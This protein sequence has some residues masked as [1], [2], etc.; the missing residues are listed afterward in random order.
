M[1]ASHAFW[2]HRAKVRQLILM[3][4]LPYIRDDIRFQ[5]RRHIA[6]MRVLWS[7]S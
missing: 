4:N 3:R 7:V 6:A 2:Y 1:L 5:I